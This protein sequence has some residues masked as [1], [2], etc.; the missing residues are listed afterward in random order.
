MGWLSYAHVGAGDLA[1]A[2]QILERFLPQQGPYLEAQRISF[3]ALLAYV[4][5]GQGRLREG[6]ALS[7][8]VLRL[9]SYH[10][11]LLP[12]PGTALALLSLGA[13]QLEQKGHSATSRHLAQAS[14]LLYHEGGCLSVPAAL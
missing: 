12:A 8:D 13:C 9:A 1:A 7:H 10:G 3:T 4:R 11:Q 5:Y 2:S 14:R 6:L